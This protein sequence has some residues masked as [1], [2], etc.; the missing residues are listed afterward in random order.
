MRNMY[1]TYIVLPNL[2]NTILS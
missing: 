1:L 2:A